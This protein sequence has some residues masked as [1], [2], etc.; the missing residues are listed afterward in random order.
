MYTELHLLWR[1]Y[2]REDYI[3]VDGIIT[4]KGRVQL[5]LFGLVY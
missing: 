4:G 3:A 5:F 2:M 1:K